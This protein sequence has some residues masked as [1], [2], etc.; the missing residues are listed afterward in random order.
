MPFP[1][2]CDPGKAK[3]WPVDADH[4]SKGPRDGFARA[5]ISASRN[6]GNDTLVPEERGGKGIAAP[7]SSQARSAGGDDVGR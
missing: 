1:Q 6:Q 5:D 7:Q 2:V 3:R 4:V